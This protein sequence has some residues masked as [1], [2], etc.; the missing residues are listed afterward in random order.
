[1]I[2]YFYKGVLYIAIY[3]LFNK[4]NL[5]IKILKLFCLYL[6]ITILNYMQGQ[7]WEIEL[8]GFVIINLSNIIRLIWRFS[9]LSRYFERQS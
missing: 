3:L 2:I 1:M 9:G 4:L 7:S 6:H 5:K 8:R